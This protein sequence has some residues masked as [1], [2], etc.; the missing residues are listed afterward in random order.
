MTH[1]GIHYHLIDNAIDFIREGVEAYFD[2]RRAALHADPWSFGTPPRND[3]PD[4]LASDEE[5]ETLADVGGIPH[6]ARPDH[7]YKYA[8]LHLHAGCLLLFKERLRREHECLIY[9]NIDLDP[10]ADR[11][12]QKTVDF[13]EA[14]GRLRT[15]TM[16][17]LDARTLADLRRLQKL[18]NN[19][20]HF[21]VK[22]NKRHAEAI[23]TL[24]VEFAYRFLR[25]ELGTNLEEEIST[26]A[27]RHV[28]EL[29]A[30]A[31]RL[32]REREEDWKRRAIDC[33]AM[34][35]D[36]LREIAAA[37]EYHPK[38]NPD[39]RDPLWCDECS[40]HTIALIAPDMFLCTNPACRAV[41]EAS[42]CIRCGGPV[43]GGGVFCEDCQGYID[44]Q[45]SKD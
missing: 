19:F 13:D 35:D 33:E 22:I 9:K 28:R 44:H 40:E 11:T 15:W 45:M 37:A 31:E 5:L 2:D 36:D 41:F 12:K 14:I 10:T 43:L 1:D 8:V 32:E 25:D 38:N 26:P 16:V 21:E 6:A 18:R 20:E 17:E 4:D 23:V 7:A 42:D 3:E 30:I 27:W 29:R 24:V 34:T 39:A